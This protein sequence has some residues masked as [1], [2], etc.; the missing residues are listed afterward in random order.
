MVQLFSFTF[1]ALLNILELLTH[2]GVPLNPY[3]LWP[4]VVGIHYNDLFLVDL[5]LDDEIRPQTRKIK[6]VPTLFG[7]LVMATELV[8]RYLGGQFSSMSLEVIISLIGYLCIF[9]EA[10]VCIDLLIIMTLE[11]AWAIHHGHLKHKGRVLDLLRNPLTTENLVSINEDRL[12][13]WAHVTHR[14]VPRLN[15]FLE[16]FLL[17]SLIDSV[18]VLQNVYDNR[19]TLANAYLR[20][21]SGILIQSAILLT[22]FFTY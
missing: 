12:R 8:P 18:V 13:I 5:C 19:A 22:I 10:Y 16:V 6:I 14:L 3:A 15:G 20:N 4:G 17:V 1:L 2:I 9:F 11:P 21:T 7:L